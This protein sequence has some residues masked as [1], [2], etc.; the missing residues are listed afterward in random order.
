MAETVWQSVW[1]F[2]RGFLIMFTILGAVGTL[3]GVFVVISAIVGWI[4]G[5]RRTERMRRQ[6]ATQWERVV[7]ELDESRRRT[8][9]KRGDREHN[10]KYT[11]M[12]VLDD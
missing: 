11:R 5:H 6:F 8:L 12:E 3:F 7:G 1:P 2:L 9:G 10:P 4:R